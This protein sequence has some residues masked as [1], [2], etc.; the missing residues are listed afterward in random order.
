MKEKKLKLKNILIRFFSIF[1][2]CFMLAN[3][4]ATGTANNVNGWWES[5]TN[6]YKDG[7]TTVSV[8]QS[9]ISGIA[10]FVEIVGTAV[11]AIATVVI[12]MKFMFGTVQ[13]K[14]E[15]KENL[16][17][18]LVACIF[19]FGWSNI[20]SL[21]ITGNA[22]GNGKLTGSTGL[23]FFQ[24]GDLKAALAQ[25]FTLTVTIAQMIAVA[26]IV[27]LGVKYV[28]AGAD[29][30]AQLKQKSPGMIVGIILIFCTITVLKV[31][32]KVVSGTF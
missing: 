5:A 7:S 9:V 22:T 17:N 21:L 1:C 2:I 24:N 25:V 27:L 19:F 8:S 12:G 15:A 31:I 29:A 3:V 28:F 6:W 11:I 23:I 10:D 14:S 4:Y 32:A 13:G 20:R 16:I 18:L 30:K 26:S